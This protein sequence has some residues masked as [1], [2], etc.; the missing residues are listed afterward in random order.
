MNKITY[1]VVVIGG[2]PAGM[3]AALKAA[4]A[5]ASTAI[6]ERNAQLGGILR[7]CIH[8]G[9]GL[10]YFKEELTG[11]E[12][13]Q[14]FIDRVENSPIKVYL[15]S[16]V[17]SIHHD[18]ESGT[19]DVVFMSETGMVTLTAHAVVLAMGCRE[20]TRSEIKIPGSRPAGVFTAGLAQRYINIENLKP[21]S[22]FV[23]LGSGDIGLIMARRLTLEGA[24][25]LGVYEVKPTPSG[26]TR[27]IHQCL[28]DFDI[29]LHLSHTV[30]RV[31]GE[32]R[33]TA[34]EVAKVDEKMQPIKGT[35]EIIECDAL[36]LS[37]GLI[38]ENEL[39]ESLDVDINRRTKGPVC[40]Q[41][42]MT[43]VEGVYSAGNCLHVNDLVDYV[44]ENALEAGRNSA[45]YEKRARK[46][47]PLS[48]DNNFLY[49]VPTVL[50]VNGD[51]S[52]VTVYFRASRDMKNARL[53]LSVDGKEVMTKKYQAVRPPEMERLK[54]NFKDFGV[55]E[56]SK[57]EFTLF[58]EE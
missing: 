7:Q 46:Y 51:T 17:L 28:I 32:D 38:P 55:N 50:D 18:D 21:G 43:S 39:A 20:R 15:G 29:P 6:V 40:D 16:M 27:N 56:N 19:S 44:T 22:R 36:I 47:V 14:R 31:F 5:G 58:E 41:N 2:G 11:P 25:V 13:A 12:Y 48:I 26:L 3:A 23:I 42:Y 8:P 34:V 54:I 53:R 4:D 45:H 10:T 37:V 24:K 30:T 49:I 9:F 57:V 52:D 35:E 33:L 1:D